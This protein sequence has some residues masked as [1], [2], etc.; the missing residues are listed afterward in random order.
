MTSL[1]S[2]NVEEPFYGQLRTDS[3]TAFDWSEFVRD[4]IKTGRLSSGD[5]LIF[6]NAAVH[7]RNEETEALFATLE[8]HGIAARRL[9]T[10]SPELNPIEMVFGY[11]KNR[12]RS[13]NATHSTMSFQDRLQEAIA[14]ISVALMRSYFE[15]CL[16]AEPWRK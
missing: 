2:L 1:V 8:L 9:P 10:Y 12:L 6:D 7:T 5:F 11:I 16:R 14:S 15:K 4:L 3:N 13:G